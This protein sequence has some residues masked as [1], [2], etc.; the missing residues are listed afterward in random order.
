MRAWGRESERCEMICRDCSCLERQKGFY[1]SYS[2]K[3]GSFGNG[4]AGVG[5]IQKFRPESQKKRGK[6][7]NGV[8]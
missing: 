2:L 3:R 8:Q 6:K 4:K 1:S 7:E 5:P